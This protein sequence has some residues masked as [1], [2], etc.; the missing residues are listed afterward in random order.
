MHSFAH[1]SFSFSRQRDHFGQHGWDGPAATSEEVLQEHD[2]ALRRGRWVEFG[3]EFLSIVV[4]YSFDCSPCPCRRSRTIKSRTFARATTRR[5]ACSRSNESKAISS[6][7]GFVL[8]SPFS[9]RLVVDDEECEDRP[10]HDPQESF[11]SPDCNHV[12]A[13]RRT[14]FLLQRQATLW[15]LLW[16]VCSF[17][18]NSFDLVRC[19][20]CSKQRMKSMDEAIYYHNSTV[21]NDWAFLSVVRD[22]VDRFLSG[23]LFSCIKCVLAASPFIPPLA[24][25]STSTP[26]ALATAS[27]VAPT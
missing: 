25:E 17:G 10:V 7:F 21:E 11:D 4:F 13:E 1:S 5:S 24:G 22:P 20:P 9:S 15:R 3:R 2:S 12:F 14:R 26:I 19:S 8:P 27:A 16:A 23:F 18:S 6:T